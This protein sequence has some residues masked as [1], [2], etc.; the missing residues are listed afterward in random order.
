M[1]KSQILAAASVLFC[2]VFF[3]IL[4]QRNKK[5]DHQKELKDEVKESIVEEHEFEETKEENRI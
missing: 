5:I 3:V 1:D 2:I 4:F